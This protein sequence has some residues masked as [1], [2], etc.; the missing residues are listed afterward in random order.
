MFEKAGR[1]EV[2]VRDDLED[3]RG[4]QFPHSTDLERD[5]WSSWNPFI[6]HNAH[7]CEGLDCGIF[8]ECWADL[9]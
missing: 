2:V 1:T 8:V 7:G 5:Q 3:V 4:A 6:L 9:E